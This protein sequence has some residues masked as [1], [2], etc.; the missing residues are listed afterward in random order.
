ML[1]ALTVGFDRVVY[2]EVIGICRGDDSDIWGEVME[3]A[4]ELIRFDHRIVALLR[5]E[6]VGLVVIGDPPEEGVAVYV[7]RAQKVSQQGRG[8]GLA[9]GTSDTEPT[10]SAGQIAQELCSLDHPIT[11]MDEEVQL[12]MISRYS[13]GEDDQGIRT[14]EGLRDELG[15][16]FVVD[17]CTLFGECFGQRRRCQ[18]IARYVVSFAEEVAYQRTHA[19]ATD[20]DKV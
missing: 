15:I 6:A 16:I 18:V 11:L 7:A 8:R 12:P 3:G 14:A 17:Q 5:D 4:I 1:E 20:T 19:Y 9:M 13:R 2:V 10:L